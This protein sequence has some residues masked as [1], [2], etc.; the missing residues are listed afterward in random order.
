MDL[1]SH[2]GGDSS[3]L[4]STFILFMDL[5]SFSGQVSPSNTMHV[6]TECLKTVIVSSKIS[7]T[8]NLILQKSKEGDGQMLV[9]F[10]GI[11]HPEAAWP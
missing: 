6:V 1:F 3:S 11:H 4:E 2:G 9:R 10:T 7:L 8:Q 5:L